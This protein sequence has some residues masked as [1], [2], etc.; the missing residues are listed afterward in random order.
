M[1]KIFFKPFV[2]L[3]FS[4][5]L[6]PG[7]SVALEHIPPA[8]SVK[9]V[10]IPKGFHAPY[11]L[12]YASTTDILGRIYGS[13]AASVKGL[14]NK[15]IVGTEWYNYKYTTAPWGVTRYKYRILVNVTRLEGGFG[16]RVRVPVE[17][18]SGNSWKYYG[19]DRKIEKRVRQD[20]MLGIMRRNY[21]LVEIP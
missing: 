11:P 20:I 15:G 19:R 21:N 3:F 5:V 16:I 12:V 8:E 14:Y 2:L 10:W 7:C 9:N 13:G 1:K 18:E 4:F 6:L 17:K